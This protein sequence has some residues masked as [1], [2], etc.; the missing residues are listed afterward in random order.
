[1]DTAELILKLRERLEM[2]T[3]QNIT[4]E[5]RVESLEEQVRELTAP[6]EG[7]DSIEVD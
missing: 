7:V 6:A 5:L 4:L 2:M 1:M 3:Y